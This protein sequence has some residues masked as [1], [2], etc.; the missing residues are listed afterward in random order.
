MRFA[1]FLP[2]F[3]PSHGRV[4]RPVLCWCWMSAKRSSL[5]TQGMGVLRRGAYRLI[6][7]L[8]ALFCGLWIPVNFLMMPWH[9]VQVGQVRHRFQFKKL[10]RLAS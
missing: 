1:V 4:F 3:M 10:G 6:M 9:A 5:V 2:T 7:I 8:Y